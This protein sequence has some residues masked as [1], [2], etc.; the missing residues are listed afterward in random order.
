MFEEMTYEAILDEMLSRVANDVDK[1]EGSVIYDALAPAAYQLAQNYFHLDNFANLVSGDTAVGEYLDK[2]AADYGITRKPATQAVR[3]INT[4][5]N[6]DIGTRW[7]LNDTS[8]LITEQIGENS[9]TAICEQS[10]EAG[11]IYIGTLESIDNVSGITANLADILVPGQ[12]EESDD[13]LRKR[14]FTK[15]RLPSTSGNANQ[16][17]QWAL[18]V[19]GVGD[20]KVFPLWNGP[21]TLKVVIV[22]SDKQPAAF[23][24]T[25]KVA[26]YIEEVR[27]IGAAVTVVSGAA[28]T[29]NISAMITLASGYGLQ[30]VTE[31]FYE[32]VTVY[33]QS[34]AFSQ[35]YISC[36]KIGTI[37]LG[38]NGVADYDGLRLNGSSSNIAL[39]DEEIPSLGSVNLEV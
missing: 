5:E 3:K 13:N 7:G 26:D 10:G 38:T 1:R 37:L 35:T 14:Y 34:I 28:K 15:V 32:A 33:F 4:S 24:L 20:G 19:P 2:A 22:D 8:Y 29:I 30:A 27:P 21:G 18:E 9:Y 36:A 31:A 12:D 39:A 11:N 6:V 16:Y 23:T 25:R 17:R